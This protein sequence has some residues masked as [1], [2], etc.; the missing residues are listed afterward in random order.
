MSER[1]TGK[2]AVQSL[3]LAVGVPLWEIEPFLAAIVVG[4]VY[5]GLRF[6]KEAV[7]MAEVW[8]RCSL[9]SS[10]LTCCV[11]QGPLHSGPALAAALT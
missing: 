6:P 9:V 1:I 7:K 11:A 4:L 3:D 2:G 8:V 5:V 10:K